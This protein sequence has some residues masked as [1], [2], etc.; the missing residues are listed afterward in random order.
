MSSNVSASETLKPKHKGQRSFEYE[1]FTNFCF[2]YVAVAIH[3]DIKMFLYSKKKIQRYTV[4][5]VES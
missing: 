4:I 1:Y 3:D 2:Y 5:P